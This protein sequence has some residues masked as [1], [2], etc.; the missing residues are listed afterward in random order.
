MDRRSKQ[1]EKIL[2]RAATQRISAHELDVLVN[3][4]RELSKVREQEL[5]H[6]RILLEELEAHQK[7]F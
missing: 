3:K 5:E 6:L 2:E 1:V 4:T 7:H